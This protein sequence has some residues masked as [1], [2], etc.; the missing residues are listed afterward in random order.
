MFAAVGK[1]VLYDLNNLDQLIRIFLFMGFGGVSL[2][3]EYYFPAL[4]KE[5]REDDG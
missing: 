2:G 3:L 1:L 4:W 5:Q